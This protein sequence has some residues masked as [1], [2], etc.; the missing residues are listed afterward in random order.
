MISRHQEDFGVSWADCWYLRQIIGQKEFKKTFGELRGEQLKSVPQGY[1]AE[2]P[3]IEYLKLKCLIAEQKISDD[4]LIRSSLHKK[5]VTAFKTLQ[6]MTE[7]I[8]RALEG[9]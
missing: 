5:I 8:N 1:D 7:F 2:N 3:A 9:E 4:E 6:P